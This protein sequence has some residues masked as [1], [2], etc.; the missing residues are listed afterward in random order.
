MDDYFLLRWYPQRISGYES[1]SF[2]TDEWMK[3]LGYQSAKL[4]L[5]M[6]TILSVIVSFSIKNASQL[7]LAELF[8]IFHLRSTNVEL[9]I[10][11]ADSHDHDHDTSG[12]S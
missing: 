1:K 3:R 9:L 10:L 8:T 12:W 2:G 11:L 5:R 4:I 7:P 6:S